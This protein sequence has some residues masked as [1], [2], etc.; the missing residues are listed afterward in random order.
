MN[1]NDAAFPS[2]SHDRFGMTIR[3]YIAA[4]AMAAIVSNSHVAKLLSAAKEHMTKDEASA[5]DNS[6]MPRV[7]AKASVALA[8]ALIAELSKS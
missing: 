5:F 6:V 7:T 8:D 4:K 3:T 1:A 2:Q